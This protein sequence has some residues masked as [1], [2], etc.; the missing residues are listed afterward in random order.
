MYFHP[1]ILYYIT[2]NSSL[3]KNPKSLGWK[4]TLDWV[5]LTFPK[6]ET[7]D[8]AEVK[9]K[10]NKDVWKDLGFGVS[11][12]TELTF[13]LRNNNKRFWG[14]FFGSGWDHCWLTG[15][16][17]DGKEKCSVVYKPSG[18]ILYLR[19][20]SIAHRSVLVLPLNNTVW[21]QRPQGQN[22]LNTAPVSYYFRTQ[23]CIYD[24]VLVYLMI[25]FMK[26]EC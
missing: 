20:S 1:Q 10:Q 13:C 8:L 25:W 7:E 23:C 17:D 4:F 12:I 19:W 9:Q 2:V 6:K 15:G 21:M 22:S 26:D 11:S 18:Y 14:T 16:W 3:K 5:L 24:L